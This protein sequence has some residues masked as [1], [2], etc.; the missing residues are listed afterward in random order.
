MVLLNVQKIPER[1]MLQQQCPLLFPEQND[2]RFGVPGTSTLKYNS[3]CRKMS[4]LAS[5]A[6]IGDDIYALMSM[7]I[8]EAKQKFVTMRKSRGFVQ[9]EGEENQQEQATSTLPQ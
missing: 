6:C 8:D 7:M 1:Y 2:I 4:D 9:N 5:D 3:L